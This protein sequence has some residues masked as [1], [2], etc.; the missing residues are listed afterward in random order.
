[1]QR[2]LQQCSL[3]SV[4]RS[5]VEGSM[6]R[7][8]A[9]LMLVGIIGVACG[10]ETA[11]P[12]D[13]AGKPRVYALLAALGDQFNVVTEVSRTGTH[14]SP[15]ARRTYQDVDRVL[16][17]LALHSLD[18]AIAKIDPESRRIYMTLPPAALDGV[19]ASERGP[20]AIA[21]IAAEL[22]KLPQ[23]GEWDRIVV[24]AP[25]YRALAVDGLGSRQQGFG[26]FV[27]SQCQAAC[28]GFRSEDQARAIARE[29]PDGVDAVTSEDKPIKARTFIAPFSYI[30]V[31]VLD[32]KTLAVVD[33]QQGFDSQKLAE[34][35]EKALD[36]TDGEAREYVTKR[37]TA[38]IDVSIGT[39]VV[40]AEP[41]LRRGTVEV[42]PVKEVQPESEPRK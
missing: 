33:R 5:T 9:A 20:V 17:R 24:A 12:V 19:P 14:L 34:P 7:A 31:W 21:R 38:L 40:H 41:S 25:A 3:G 16:D 18:Q 36:L 35:P 28:G 42:G 10:Q 26:L 30:E 15:Y 2:K 6:M 4:E 39:A 23:R 22:E 27:E 13:P 11:Q 32:P 8:L 37:I 1:M 29:P